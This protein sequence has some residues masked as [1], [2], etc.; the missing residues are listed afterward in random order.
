MPAPAQI[1]VERVRILPSLAG[2]GCGGVQTRGRGH[3]SRE[4]PH[5]RKTPSTSCFRLVSRSDEESLELALAGEL[6]M[7]ATF[8]IEPELDRLLSGQEV[9][10]LVLDVAGIRFI[11]S[12]GLGA[13]LSIRERTEQLGIEMTLIN[14]TDPVR[15]IL[16][17]SGGTAAVL[18]D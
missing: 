7:A 4:L 5:D 10:R 8:R 16:G 9:R 15:R 14:V 17:R 1:R 2:E 3:P 18:T 13:L 11:D 12:A 6:D